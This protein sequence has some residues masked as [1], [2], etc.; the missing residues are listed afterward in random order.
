[1]LGSRYMGKYKTIGILG[2]MGPGAT[3]DLYGKIIR[4]MQTAYGAVQ[5]NEFPPILIYNLPLDGFDETGFVDQG[6]VSGQLIRGVQCLERAGAEVIV[7]GCNTIH[8]FYREMQN[9]VRVP[10]LNI[11]DEAV[12]QSV[13]MGHQKV[14]IVGSQS[15]RELDLYGKS[16][17]EYGLNT[18]VAY[19]AE[20]EALNHII[21]Q[22]MA[23]RHNR[24]DTLNLKH[25]IMN[26]QSRG[27]QAIILGCTELP[28]AIDQ[29]D[30]DIPVF[31]A[32]GILAQQ[33]VEY[34]VSGVNDEK[35]KRAPGFGAR[36]IDRLLAHLHQDAVV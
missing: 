22:V 24:Y 5:D 12:K 27:A 2:G 18:I 7:V 35:E 28:L 25:I 34:A 14:G 16:A 15:T 31:D 36:R 20:Q 8:Y 17:K 26:L 23:G 19:E 13:R 29:L 3:V 30:V 10:I 21:M 11:I 32:T 6:L 33:V 9:A 4:C 1:M